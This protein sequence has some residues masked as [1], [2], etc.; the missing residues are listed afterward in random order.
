M[1]RLLIIFLACVLIASCAA[2]PKKNDSKAPN[3]I[4]ISV[5]AWRIESRYS[6]TNRSYLFK[7][8]DNIDYQ[9]LIIDISRIEGV[10]NVSPAFYQ[11]N[12][13]IAGNYSWSDI[14]PEIVK[15][16]DNVDSYLLV[17]EPELNENKK[18]L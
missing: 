7:H 9:A 8:S 12:I 14:E 4:K 3:I 18:S 6:E 13:T 16:L 5:N 17:I 10:Q 11:L 15:I 1:K 2:S